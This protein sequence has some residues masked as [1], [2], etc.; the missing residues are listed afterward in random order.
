[1]ALGGHEETDAGVAVYS[2]RSLVH[3]IPQSHHEGVE[4]MG[5]SHGTLQ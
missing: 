5:C 3:P 1:M 2:T 4:V